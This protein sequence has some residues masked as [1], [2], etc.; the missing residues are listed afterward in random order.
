MKSLNCCKDCTGLKDG[1][2]RNKLKCMFCEEY[3]N[4]A[5]MNLYNELKAKRGCSTCAHCKHIY[6]YPAYVTAEECVCMAGLE[7]D[8]VLFSVKN[9]KEW[10]GRHEE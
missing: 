8:T 7:C 3:Q 5:E 4:E 10:V 9:C 6:D 2:F 1:Q